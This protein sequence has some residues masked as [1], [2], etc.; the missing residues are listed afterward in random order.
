MPR[1]F[2][3]KTPCS[4]E[5]CGKR[6][7][8]E[9]YCAMHVNRVRRYGSPGSVESSRVWRDP[10]CTIEGC[11]RPHDAFGLCKMHNTRKQ[12]HG[13]IGPA[14]PLYA[15]SGSGTTNKYSGYRMVRHNGKQVREHRLVMSQLLGRELEPFEEVH[16]KNGIRHDN[17]PEN[18]E[19][20]LT[21]Q[22]RGQSV[23]D[24]V[25]FVVDHYADLVSERLRSRIK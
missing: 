20:W 23:D 12:R 5:G 10:T 24:L 22:P 16:H 19:L 1:G 17:R 25:A 11:V 18:L 3:G 21:H 9:G 6:V 4:V 15:A 7:N 13:S 2:K 8:A 14:A